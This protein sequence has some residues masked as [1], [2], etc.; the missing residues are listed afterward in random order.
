VVTAATLPEPEDA[1]DSDPVEESSWAL[2][3]ES[4][5][6]VED[7]CA[8]VEESCEP[9]EDAGALVEE[10]A[11]RRCATVAASTGSCPVVR[12]TQMSA[13]TAMNSETARVATRRRRIVARR[14]REGAEVMGTPSSG[15]L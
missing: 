6:L 10:V 5:A 14:R 12:R 15:R 13:Q 9:V 3:E 1:D 7:S 4:C 11:V 2:V 8:L